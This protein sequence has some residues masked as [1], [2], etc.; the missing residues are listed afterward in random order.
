MTVDRRIPL[1]HARLDETRVE[2]TAGLG[3]VATGTKVLMLPFTRT[4][5]A[6]DRAEAF[7][8]RQEGCMGKGSDLRVGS[9]TTGTD[10]VWMTSCARGQQIPR[11]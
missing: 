1:L 9:A 10:E 6:A 7:T 3:D 2:S 4:W 11:Q 8:S 5:H